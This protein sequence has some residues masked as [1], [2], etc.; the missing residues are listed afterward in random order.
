MTIFDDIESEVQSYARS[1][2]CLITKS[3][4]DLIHDADGKSYIDFLSGAGT[5]NYGHNNPVFKEKLIEYIN[6][7][8]IVHSLD[9]HTQAKQEFLQAFQDKILK[10]R[11]LQY[12]MQFTGPTG[13]NTVEAA[14]KLARTITG[15]ENIIAFTN[16]FHGVSLGALSL[17]ANQLHRSA[18]GV[19]LS[20]CTRMPFDGYLGAE[21]DTTEYLDKVLSDSSSGVDK[22][23]AVMVET[24]Q[25][26]GGV[27]A[28]SISWL[29]NLEKV[30]RKHD[31]LLIVDD[32]QTGCGRTG[33]FFSF[34][35]SGIKPDMVT[36]SK[37]LGGYGLPFAVL[38]IKPEIDK[39]KP[40]Q[41]NGT[42]RGNNFAFVT[43]KAALDNYWSDDT[44]SNQ[45]KTK[46]EKLSNALESIVQ[47]YD[48]GEFTVRGRGMLK[49]I[50]CRQSEVAG[51]VS[52][53]AFEKGM[54]IETSGSEDQVLKFLSPLTISDEHLNRGLEIIEECLKEVRA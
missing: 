45:I 15:R 36:L 9:M 8:G 50:Y 48:E 34:E 25:G 12:K 39:W 32:I 40:G 13:T 47:Q 51:Q 37:S 21:T 7:N 53:L 26:E 20:G 31:V 4:G 33:D 6:S 23:A 1:F 2:P 5:L 30:C 18:A 10:P 17:T 11:K 43:A 22:P 52:H 41:H 19:S 35:E 38:L 27:I 49:G 24:I 54:I 3:E 28:A 42:F 16:G 46:S 14:I 29:Q 44:F